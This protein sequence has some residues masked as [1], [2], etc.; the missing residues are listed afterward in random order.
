MS[1]KVFNDC[2]NLT[3]AVFEGETVG[4]DFDQA[5][6]RCPSLTSVTLPSKLTKLPYGLFEE[7]HNLQSLTIPKTVNYIST[8]VFKNTYSL[9][10][11]TFETYTAE[12]G[13]D[14]AGKSDLKE[15]CFNAFNNSAIQ[16]CVLPD[17]TNGSI[18]YAT[19]ARYIM[20]IMPTGMAI[21]GTARGTTGVFYNC[22]YLESV[23]ISDSASAVFY[24]IIKDTYSLKTVT[25]AGGSTEYT[26]VNPFIYKGADII[27]N[28]SAKVDAVEI[29]AYVTSIADKMFAYKYINKVY[30]PDRIT[31]IGAF[32]FKGCE[33]LTEV[34]FYKTTEKTS[35]EGETA[36]TT[37][38]AVKDEQ[39][40]LVLAQ[41]EDIKL[42][43]IGASA[44]EGCTKLAA[45]EFYPSITKIENDAFAGCKSLTNV[46]VPSVE[47]GANVFGNCTGLTSATVEGKPVEKM[48]AGCTS[49]TT[50]EFKTN[51]KDLAAYAFEG[52]T[53]LE[54]VTLP[55]QLESIGNYA[56][57]KSGL[58]AVEMP[59]TLAA[60]GEY[61][62]YG[63]ENL[64]S[65]TFAADAA[66]TAIRD[67]AFLDCAKLSAFDVKNLQNLATIGK[68]AFAKTGFE[69][70]VFSDS[71]VT[72]GYAESLF[73]DSVKLKTVYLPANVNYIP[74]KAFA[75]CTALTKV[76]Y[77]GY[78]GD[79]TFAL[80][81]TTTFVA[82]YAFSNTG[83]VYADISNIA[84]EGFGNGLFKDCFALTQVVLNNELTKISNEAFDG[85]AL[86]TDVKL[87]DAL[88]EIGEAA[89]RS[90]GLTTI[91][92]AETIKTID[93]YAFANTAIAKVQFPDA[94]RK[95]GYGAFAN[96]AITSLD[97]SALD[98]TAVA[99]SS[100]ADCTMLS[101]VI[102]SDVWTAIPADFFKGCSALSSVVLPSALA[103]IGDNAFLG[104]SS[105]S[106]VTIDC[107]GL[108]VI[109]QKA[110]LGTA[111]TSVTIPKTVAKIG[112]GAFAADTL[113]E[114]EIG[115]NTNFS[116]AN[117]FLFDKKGNA[118]LYYGD[119]TDIDLSNMEEI[120]AEFFYGSSMTS[121]VIPASVKTIGDGAF[122]NSDITTV[123][124][125]ADSKLE[126]I[127]N[128]AF[129][130]SKLQQITIPAT[131]NA[132]GLQAFA[133]CGEL[134]TVVL[135]S[136]KAT[137]GDEVF[138][139]C[140][141]LS[142]VTLP[143]ELTQI[144]G[145]NTFENCSA[146]TSIVLPTALTSLGSYAF[147][148]SGLTSITIPSKITV[149]ME[150]TFKN[151]K[152]LSTVTFA[153]GNNFTMVSYYAFAG[154]GI[155]AIEFP[156]SLATIQINAFENCKQLQK[157]TF[158]ESATTLRLYDCAFA[159]CTAIS[160]IV[161]PKNV[162]IQ[163]TSTSG[164]FDGVFYGWTANQ[165][166][167]IM[168]NSRKFLAANAF[169]S[170]S[171]AKA[172]WNGGCNA[173]IVYEYVA[174]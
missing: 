94:I 169:T 174:E 92:V 53:S 29:P 118:I 115:D 166:I 96:T 137:F 71:I 50:V 132:I 156:A 121:I 148:N 75:G 95:I 164:K 146:L 70:F 3:T 126:K 129:F 142:S 155:T 128:R 152:N 6:Y 172:H 79:K 42:A 11:V 38:E 77:N 62:F 125:A 36:V 108:T 74:Q 64:V 12:D 37:Y 85:C 159:G 165:T 47:M 161:L 66:L 134:T 102:L 140:A 87:P 46:V 67:Y 56:F 52:C 89:F 136:A 39:G 127:G 98:M 72:L 59:K 84:S 141:K 8:N 139:D 157:V 168:A 58:K 120:P 83:L 135:N 25:F 99:E 16:N 45:F 119:K 80:P 97:L 15:I 122:E 93:K 49:L 130:G 133:C 105:L 48:F 145:K 107:A 153:E 171:L 41:A 88:T 103:E 69:T 101:Q 35:G 82:E 24:D 144:N 22:D 27:Y 163:L 151:C 60:I 34:V 68:G 170:Y 173:K 23:T 51:F 90:T 123:T 63:C 81:Q 31:S 43:T 147:A 73:E 10:T 110:F 131:V 162:D 117:G 54:S 57:S 61:A 138:K 91:N 14:K 55:T 104:C 20:M 106:S 167:K 7:C 143:D 9:K 19:Q 113:K 150:G 26:I 5:F 17:S 86:L 33:N 2:P 30:L 4:E 160:E 109:G 76:V 78:T 111:L 28:F 154:S 112:N 40:Q 44:F 1:I 18:A 100:F 21:K 114:I 124:F 116:V 149:I 13:A 65:A 158:A 32:A